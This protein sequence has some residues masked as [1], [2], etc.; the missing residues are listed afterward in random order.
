[1]TFMNDLKPQDLLRLRRVVRKVH[2]KN[3]PEALMHDR[4]ADRIIEALGPAI[5]ERMVKIAVDND[6]F[7]T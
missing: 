1:M 7:G 2:M 6:L 4:E 5:A 3:Y